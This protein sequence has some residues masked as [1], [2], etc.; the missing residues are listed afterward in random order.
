MSRLTQTIGRILLWTYPR[1]S[2]QWDLCC[3][4]FL[5][6]IFTTPKGFL[7]DYTRVP[8]TSAE[9]RTIL[10]DWFASIFR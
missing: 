3:G 8:L 7:L 6:I 5:V 10:Y 1:G 4:V 9:I 2:W